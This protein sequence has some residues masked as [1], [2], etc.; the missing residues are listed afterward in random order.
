MVPE[1]QLPPRLRGLPR[2]IQVH[3]HPD[4]SYATNNLSYPSKG[5]IWGCFHDTSVYSESEHVQI[6]EFG[7]CL[8][9]N[10]EWV[11]STIYGRPYST[12]EF[13]QWFNCPAGVL[14]PG[15]RYMNRLNYSAMMDQLDFESHAALWYYIGRKADGSE[16]KGYS[17]VFA[18]RRPDPDPKSQQVYFDRA[19]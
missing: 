9:R 14:E 11:L 6:T 3:E 8:Y 1:E 12:G 16:V 2:L 5:K 17:L 15:K 4:I 13:E 19:T 10:K 18:V 7:A